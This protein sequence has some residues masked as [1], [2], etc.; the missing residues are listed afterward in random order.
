MDKRYTVAVPSASALEEEVSAAR[1]R[2]R[3]RLEALRALSAEQVA[4][5][6]RWRAADPPAPKAGLWA[7]IGAALSRKGASRPAPDL[8]DRLEAVQRRVLSLAHHLDRLAAD[9]AVLKGEIEAIESR[10]AAYA[11]AAEIA[12]D[13]IAKLSIEE[14]KAGLGARGLSIEAALAERS[15]DRRAFLR[16]IDRLSSVAALHREILQVDTDVEER[17]TA[18]HAAGT[19]LLDALDA[20][21]ARIAT[22]ARARELMDAFASDMGA[23]RE[24]VARV[25]RLATEGAVLLTEQLDRLADEVDPISAI[26]PAALAAERELAVHLRDRSV[27]DAVARARAK[28]GSRPARAQAPTEGEEEPGDEP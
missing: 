15:A 22:E 25:N 18:L 6:E 17:L 9:R 28:A 8:E 3:A 4:E 21:L 16:A 14:A 19:R 11:R 1:A 12:A 7:K 27:A 20:D 13:A 2:H 23:L 5:S 24:S 26:D 10:I